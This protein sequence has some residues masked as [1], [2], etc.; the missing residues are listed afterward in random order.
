MLC[1]AICIDENAQVCTATIVFRRHRWFRLTKNWAWFINH[2]AGDGA[3][4]TTSPSVL[5]MISICCIIMYWIWRVR[6]FWG[7]FQR[8]LSEAPCTLSNQVFRGGHSVFQGGQVPSGP[9]KF[10]HWSR[11]SVQWYRI[12]S[13]CAFVFAIVDNWRKQRCWLALVITLETVL[14][15]RW[16]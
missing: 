4:S 8:R 11:T 1:C 6:D 16:L 12:F 3:C 5:R 9:L 2:V 14:F 10:D 13:C 15:T 7:A